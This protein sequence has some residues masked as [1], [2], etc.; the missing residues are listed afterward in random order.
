M[1]RFFV[2]GILAVVSSCSGD[3]KSSLA[4]AVIDT[5]PGGIPRV[6][7]PGPTAW[8]DTSGWK[9][10]EALRIEGSDGYSTII[11]DPQSLAL[12]G[13]GRVYV[14]DQ[15]PA[16]IKVFDRAG[17]LVRTIGRQGGGPGEF[18]VGFIVIHGANLVVHDPQQAR[19]SV[20]DTSGTFTKSWATLCC[21]WQSIVV[22]RDGLVYIPGMPPADSGGMFIRY[23]LDGTTSDTLFL[24]RGPEQKNWT[25][26]SGSGKNRS[27]MST[28]VPLSPGLERVV[29]PGG[30]FLSG[31]SERYEL[32]QSPHGRDSAL[33][34]GRTWAP[35]PV[36]GSRRQAIVDSTIHEVGK[37]WGEDAARDQVKL[38]DV[39]TSAPAF[40]A[41]GVDGHGNRWIMVD[42][43]DDASHTWFDVFDSTGVYLGKVAGPPGL[44]GWRMT[45]GG[46]EMLAYLEND[47]GEPAV[48][49]Y[50]IQ[51]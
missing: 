31:W 36:S 12:D 23:R 5:L 19:T 4:K 33:V 7:S 16:V 22:D 50:R 41:I 20:F 2:F 10:V 46:D 14:A 24:S 45:W 6:M 29:N 39:P 13:E 44:V 37:Y 38:A 25:F 3:P 43:G 1:R 8:A 17:K 28:S 34:F 48:V 40:T 21:Y 42:P 18:R 35:T 30:G 27:M 15:S 26:T 9:L 51:R 49:K 11:N 47:E 32:V